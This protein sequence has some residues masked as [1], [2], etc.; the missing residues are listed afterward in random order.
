MKY[1]FVLGRNPKLSRAEIYS[2][3][4]ARNIEYTEFFYDLNNLILDFKEDPKL[5]IQEFGGIIM[6]GRVS[7]SG[8]RK[9]LLEFI[10][11]ED[12]IPSDKF[13]FNVIGNYEIE[14]EVYEKFRS[15]KRKVMIRHGRG[16]LKI[17][18]EKSIQVPTADYHLFCLKHNKIY[19]GI[20]EQTYSYSD[21]RKRDMSKPFRREELAISPRLSKILIN[22]AQLKQGNIMLDPFCGIGGILQEALVKSINVYG[23]D[24]DKMA[25]QSAT[26]NIEWLKKH[27]PIANYE[28]K[29]TDARNAP[30]IGFDG[31]ATESS[32]GELIKGNPSD[33][34]AK[35]FVSTFEKSIVPLLQRFRN[36]KKPDAKIAITFPV[37][38]R[39]YVNIDRV[40]NQT[41]LKLSSINGISFP[42]REFREDQYVSREIVVFV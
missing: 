34:D 21:V 2:Y 1:F 25:I 30:G 22:L 20:I 17:Q 40:C 33:Y 32:L 16:E 15:E 18:G 14:Q 13:T 8:A 11:K 36:V 5:N 24:K 35:A 6:C 19:F 23:I 41:G 7:F 29:N 10:E 4:Q 28:L 38:K 39:F 3:L 37:V 42:I 31:I 9:E 27:Y 12:L 26:K